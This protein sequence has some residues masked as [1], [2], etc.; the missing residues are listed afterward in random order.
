MEAVEF[1]DR[2]GNPNPR[3]DGAIQQLGLS[4]GEKADLVEFLE[5]LSGPPGG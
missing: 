2:G 1:Y 3:I 4:E 5:S